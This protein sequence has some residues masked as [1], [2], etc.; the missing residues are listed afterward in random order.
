MRYVGKYGE[1][2][3]ALAKG[4]GKFRGLKAVSET[5][6]SFDSR[7]NIAA[8]HLTDLAAHES[9]ETVSIKK[10]KMATDGRSI[11]DSK[12]VDTG[13]TYK[14]TSLEDQIALTGALQERLAAIR[15]KYSV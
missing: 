14:K 10:F 15:K 9:T 1:T 7:E 2:M 4:V 5:S 8:R 3:T 11:V 13:L 12:L 6:L